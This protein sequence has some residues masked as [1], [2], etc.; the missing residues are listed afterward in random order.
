MFVL[1]TNVVSELRKK[2]NADR[3]VAE[4]ASAKLAPELFISV[5]TVMELEYGVL[6]AARKDAPKAQ[7]L[8]AWVERTLERFEGRILDIDI[9]AARH[10][11]ALHV[12]DPKPE[13]DALIAATAL[14]HD[15]TLVTRNIAHFAKTGIRLLNPWTAT[16]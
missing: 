2:N 6:L 4:W 15:M 16:P 11:A 10:C 3:N 12:P 5:I 1:D 9:G 7:M 13:R 8:R 14:A